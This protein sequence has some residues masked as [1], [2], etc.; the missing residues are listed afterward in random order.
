MDSA[1]PDPTDD[2]TLP[3]AALFQAA[4]EQGRAWLDDVIWRARAR[5]GIAL[6]S[7]VAS[8]IL[9]FVG[10][11]ALGGESSPVEERLPLAGSATVVAAAP[12]PTSRPGLHI[13]L[14]GEV[15][16]PGLY[17]VE[18]GSRVAD[19]L[20]AAGGP[21]PIGDVDRLN[22]A[23]LLI[24]GQRIYVPAVGGSAEVADIQSPSGPL[25]LNLAAETEL[26][27]LP[28]IGPSLAAAIVRHRVS[29]GAFISVEGLLAVPGIG[30]VTLD[31]LRDLVT[32]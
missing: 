17:R 25:N 14:A 29:H 5:P 28:G 15:L 27:S 30:E 31:R 3:P 20:E 26:E 4:R 24:D 1:D 18:A 9:L 11:W 6:I 23:A 22:L 19:V 13:H 12:T 8:A 21:T 10:W 2:P 32:V 7:V 16:H